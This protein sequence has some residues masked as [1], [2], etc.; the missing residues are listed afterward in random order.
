MKTQ[1]FKFQTPTR[2]AAQ[3]KSS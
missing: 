1:N 3:V 2:L